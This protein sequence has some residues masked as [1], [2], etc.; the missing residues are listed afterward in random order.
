MVLP[1]SVLQIKNTQGFS[2]PVDPQSQ[3]PLVSLGNGVCRISVFWHKHEHLCQ[4]VT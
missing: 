1:V 3:E 4:H 2:P